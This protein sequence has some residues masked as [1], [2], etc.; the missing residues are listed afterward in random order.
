MY[1][2]AKENDQEY[3]EKVRWCISDF[4]NDHDIYYRYGV[5]RHRLPG[6]SRQRPG[7]QD[8]LKRPPR[9]VP[10][11]VIWSTDF[12]HL[13]AK[14]SKRHTK[15]GKAMTLKKT[16]IRLD[17]LKY[18]VQKSWS[19]PLMVPVVVIKG[20]KQWIEWKRF[21]QLTDGDGQEQWVGISLRYYAANRQWKIECMDYDAGRIYYQHRLV[22]PCRFECK[23]EDL[24]GRITTSLDIYR[25]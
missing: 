12:K 6:S 13:P 5:E 2:I 11:K 17:D 20:K 21:V 15:D 14:T 4:A 18:F 24:A 25:I 9:A 3:V 7:F 8:A 10:I 1:L 16:R 22:G 19:D 23:F